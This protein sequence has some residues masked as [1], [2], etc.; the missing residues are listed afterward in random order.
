PPAW[1][2]RFVT[3]N[4]RKL[5]P[6]YQQ[7]SQSDRYIDQKDQTPIYGDQYTANK[8]AKSCAQAAN[9]GPGPHCAD[10][11][12]GRKHRKQKAWRSWRQECRS[13]RLDEAKDDQRLHTVGHGACGRRACKKC[14][15]KQEAPISTVALGQTSE[16][17]Q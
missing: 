14:D 6:T 10:A 17:H 2:G 3:R 13:R 8:R 15:A 11:T 4:L 16:K 5:P 7:G 9:G 1:P 12:L